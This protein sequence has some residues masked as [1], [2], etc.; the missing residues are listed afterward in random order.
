[1]TKSGG[2]RKGTETK[3]SKTQKLERGKEGRE[4][5]GGEEG[6]RNERGNRM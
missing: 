5:L 3:G 1:M 4:I 2:K 6:L